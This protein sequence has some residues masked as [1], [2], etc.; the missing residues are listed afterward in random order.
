MKNSDIYTKFKIE[1][2]KA[3][4]TESYP[5]LTNYEI[6]TILDKAYLALIAQKLTGN[7]V[8]KV[9]FEGDIKAIE[10]T[11][12][13][14]TTTSV[15]MYTKDKS[16]ENQLNY[17]LPDDLLYY[18]N[19]IV[20]EFGSTT[21]IDKLSHSFQ[22]V[23]LVSHE[24]ANRFKV[25]NNNLPWIKQP[26]AYIDGTQLHLLVDPYRYNKTRG[27]LQLDVTYIKKPNKFIDDVDSTGGLS[28][29]STVTFQ[30]SDSMAEELINLAIIMS[31][32]IVESPRLETKTQTHILES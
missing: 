3:N 24:N 11:R 6:A 20:K 32:E 13:L 12:P 9:S 10:D 17:T 7:N 1:Y 23:M 19:S 21:A 14:I 4:V 8:R 27:N 28:K 2:D 25:F 31:A 29:A 18:I 16:V 30:L 15:S 22:D 5:S 26:V